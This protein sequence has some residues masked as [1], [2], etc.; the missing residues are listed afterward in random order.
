MLVRRAFATD[1]GIDPDEE[2]L[3]KGYAFFLDYYREHKLDFTY[4]YD[5]VLEALA[6]LRTV[7]EVWPN[8]RPKRMP[9]R[10][11]APRHGRAH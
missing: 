8:L 2:S 10:C 5:G 4:A 1:D 9:S 6:A 7:H 11:S 3:A